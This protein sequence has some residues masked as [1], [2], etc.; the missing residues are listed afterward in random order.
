MTH[1]STVEKCGF[2]FDQTSVSMINFRKEHPQPFAM[3]AGRYHIFWNDDPGALFAVA[4]FLEFHSIPCY[5]LGHHSQ[6]L[7]KGG[8]KNFA[9]FFTAVLVDF[10]L[11]LRGF[12]TK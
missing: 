6:V 2:L 7:F 9:D 8:R 4:C 12:V 11:R 3:F 10:L 1:D 5:F